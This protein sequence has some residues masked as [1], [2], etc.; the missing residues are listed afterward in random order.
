MIN[1]L[2]QDFPELTAILLLLAGFVAAN[3]LSRLTV[4]GIQLTENWLQDHLNFP[5]LASA[6]AS[7][8]ERGVY[9]LVL[10]VFILAALRVLGLDALSQTLDVMID[11][12]PGLVTGLV[13]MLVGY[14]AGNFTYQ[15]LSTY[16][17]ETAGVIVPRLAQ[18]LVVVVAIVTGLA[19]MSVEVTFIAVTIIAILVTTLGTLGLAFA[20]GSRDYVAGLLARRAFSQFSIG[21]R[22]RMDD[23]EG[24]IVEF[25]DRSVMIQS[26]EGIAVVPASVFAS[27]IVVRKTS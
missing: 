8:I 26:D 15:M 4:K 18:I 23:L 24:T 14:L 21:D 25:T 6:T 16:L 7:L 10:A 19:Q 3:L 13:I 1:E 20:L 12:I 22:V 5:V 2:I 17:G 11:A 27:A 9:Y